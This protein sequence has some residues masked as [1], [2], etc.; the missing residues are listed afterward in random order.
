M[1]NK[2][3]NNNFSSLK[4]VLKKQCLVLPFLSV[5]M[6]LFTACTNHASVNSEFEKALTQK[7]CGDEFFEQNLNKVKNKDD[8]IYTGLNTGLIARNCGKFTISNTLFDAAEDSYKEDVDLENTLQKGMKLAATTLV[9]DTIIDYKG[10]L[11]ERI[12]VNVYK[13][14]NFMS[15][16]D[17]TNARVEFNRALMRQD[18]AK[19]YFANEIKKNREEIEEAKKDPNYDKNMNDNV[20]TI[21]KEYE[22]LFKEFDT[23]KKFVNPYA[24]YLASVFFFME[25][26]YRKASDLFRE[27]AIINPKNN[28]IKKESK[29]FTERARGTN[30]KNS[31]KYIFVVYEGGMGVIKDDFTLTLPFVVNEKIIT[32]SIALQKLQKRD[33]SFEYLQANGVKTTQIVDLDDIVATEF[34]INMPTMITKAVAQTILKTAINVAA[35]NNDSTGGLLSAASS[36]ITAGTNKA[37]VRTWRGLPKNVSVA[38]IENKGEIEIKDPK[39]GE[40][41]KGKVESTKDALVFVRSFEPYLPNH[42]EIVQ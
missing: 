16:K 26:D 15:L 2:S 33:S 14:L 18:K 21:T 5:T 4:N 35:A 30:S 20:A 6:L 31:K 23:T 17:Y 10:S 7:F 9:N 36:L 39:G 42:I 1:E 28:E 25:Q 37:D 3:G 11:Y 24:T 34:K 29:L 22:H 19:E 8:T 41:F 40:I 12:M 27:I 32:T 38:M 13:G